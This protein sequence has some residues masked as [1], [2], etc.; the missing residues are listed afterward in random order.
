M[1]RFLYFS[2]EAGLAEM[3][4]VPHC[5]PLPMRARWGSWLSV[6]ERMRAPSWRA[7]DAGRMW[8]F[9]FYFLVGVVL[10]VECGLEICGLLGGF[11]CLG[12]AGFF[13][14]L[15]ISVVLCLSFVGEP[16]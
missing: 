15:G 9:I 14:F 16:S 1:T 12:N 10:R 2:C 8:C 4:A 5:S 11:F 6:K 3:E 7:E 13:F